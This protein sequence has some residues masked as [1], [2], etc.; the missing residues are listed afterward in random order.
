MRKNKEKKESISFQ[1]QIMSFAG[2]NVSHHY[3][4]VSLILTKVRKDETLVCGFSD[5]I[6]F[7]QN[8]LDESTAYAV[9]LS[10][11]KLAQ[12]KKMLIK[13]TA[14]QSKK[15]P[16]IYLVQEIRIQNWVFEF[17]PLMK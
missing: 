13:V 15:H 9:F 8:K 11:L 3:A 7:N 2:S 14:F 4:S 12:Q 1:G 6:Y 17:T 5:H 10:Y 16:E